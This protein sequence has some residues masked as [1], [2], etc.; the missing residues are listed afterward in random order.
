MEW[1]G[2]SVRP[3]FITGMTRK[4]PPLLS[5]SSGLWTALKVNRFGRVVFPRPPR[6]LLHAR[7]PFRRIPA[8]RPNPFCTDAAIAASESQSSG[9]KQECFRFIAAQSHNI[10]TPP[11]ELRLTRSLAAALSDLKSCVLLLSGP[12]GQFN[13]LKNH[14][15]FLPLGKLQK[16]VLD[17]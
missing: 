15:R 13:R 11:N 8:L 12:G 16:W 6:F 7:S 2:E 4:M 17:P 10:M 14:L 3:C 1:R 9:G 5:N